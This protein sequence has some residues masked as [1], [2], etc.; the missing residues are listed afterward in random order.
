MCLSHDHAHCSHPSLGRRGFMVGVAGTAGIMMAGCTTGSQIADAVPIL[1]SPEQEAQLGAETW[2]RIRQETPVSDN[3][4]MQAALEQVGSRLLTAAGEN[5]NQWEM[6]VFE[7]Q[8]ANAFALPGGKIGVY[9]GIFNYME[10]DAQ[11]AAVVGHEIGHNQA[12]HA[13]QRIS[14]SQAS[15]LGVQVITAALGG[16]SGG[17]ASADQIAALLGAGVQY[18]ILMP[19]GRDQELEADR[20]GLRLMAMAGYDPRESIDFWQKMSQAPGGGTPEFASTHPSP[21]NRVAQLQSL[22]PEAMAIYNS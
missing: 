1:I 16:G 13:A 19:Y 9:E 17:A 14:A 18:G 5:P 8:E 2:A 6:V 22:M 15:Q 12:R 10:N 7:G 11:L 3:R 21:G 20:L 4:S